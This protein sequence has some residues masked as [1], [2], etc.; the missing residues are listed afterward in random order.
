MPSS[1]DHGAVNF[2]TA[3]FP[4]LKNDLYL[5]AA[6]G[7]QT[8]RA[9]VWCMRQ[10]GRYLSEFRAIRVENEF[11][12]VCRTPSL[13]TEVTLQPLRRYAGLLDAAIIFSDI[14]V[15]PQ[16]MGLDVE[17]V[18]GKG[19]HFPSP[20]R[21]PDDLARLVDRNEGFSVDAQ[22]D[23][24]YK[25]LTNTR[26]ALG[27]QVP[28]LGFVGAPW[29]LMAYMIEGGGSKTFAAA[30][31]WLFAH[32]AAAHELLARLADVTARFLIGQVRAGAQALQVF[33]S[34]AGELGPRDFAEF[35]L[36]YLARIAARVKEAYPGV[37]ITVFAKGAHYALELLATETV[38][39][40]ISLD[41]TVDPRTARAR[42]EAALRSKSVARSVVLQG[43]LDPTVLFADEQTIRD[44]TAEM[45]RA[46]GPTAH[47]ANLGH[48]MMPAHDPEH[49]RV[50]L[51]AVH[52]SSAELRQ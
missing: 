47:I 10:A 43:N 46:F 39:D 35:S 42:V 6:R 17:M 13:A 41:W 33:E 15:V 29:T 18:P 32:R 2:D 16:A 49:L 31:T 7:E 19:P 28:L 48:G 4:P 40:V 45:C 27:G 50:F 22:L 9:P 52:Q 20:L 34:W 44:R 14:L 1:S 26:H 23:Y 21:S 5:R 11:F 36:P 25:A 30:K 3:R 38:Y 24:V 12:R 51:E 8:E 37:P